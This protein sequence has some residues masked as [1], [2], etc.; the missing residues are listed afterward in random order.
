VDEDRA[1]NI[2]LVDDDEV[3][4][5][6]VKRAFSSARL[7]NR[8]FVAH[9]GDEALAALRDGTWPRERRIMLLDLNMPRM[10]GIELLREIRND[11]ELKG[12]IV[13]VMT[14]STDERDRVE[15]FQLNV[16]GYIVKPV[17]F[18]KFSDAVLKVTDYWSLMQMP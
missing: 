8:L 1:L 16:S 12:L 6:I 2:L 13:I 15:A 17:T 11:P 7:T 4:V 14:T 18:D 9:D 10:N 5:I 3:D